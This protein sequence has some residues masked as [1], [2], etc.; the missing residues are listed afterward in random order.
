M[1]KK[2]RKTPKGVRAR[3][4]KDGRWVYDALVKIDGKQ[5]SLGTFDTADDAAV[6]RHAHFKLEAEKGV[7]VPRDTGVFT[8]AQLGAMCLSS[9]WDVDRW[10]YRVLETAEFADWPATQVLDEHVQLWVDRMATT[11]IA[12][13][14]GA[15]E[16][17]SYG[18]VYSPLSLLRRV[19]RW[20]MKPARKYVTHNPAQHVTISN[21]TDQ[22]L[23]KGRNLLDYLREDEVKRLLDADR[24]K[25]PLAPRTKFLVQVFSGARPSDTWRLRWERVDWAAESIRFTSSKTSKQEAR[26]YTVHMLPQ[27]LAA[28]KEWW[29]AQG[30]PT[31]GLVFPADDEGGTFARGYDGGWADRHDRKGGPDVRVYKGYRRKVGI[32]RDV[33][34][35]ALRHTCASHLLLGTELF[36]GGRAWSREEVQ[37][38]LGHLDS[39]A[40]E[41]YMRSL[42]ILGRR[43][44][45]ESKAAL[46]AAKKKGGR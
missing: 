29:M 35:Y 19:Y 39:K 3:Q 23:K 20:A 26:D 40:T 2:P 43:A 13:G 30:R 38:Q 32:A 36:T 41:H 10:R 25:L 7:R 22:R 24:E 18:T 9:E 46:K 27:L 37:S 45:M 14:R 4:L 11:P 15:G 34:L 12:K 33:P 16:L 28:L 5:R 42:G 8:V 44:A 6:E 1:K 17:P 21:S 31:S